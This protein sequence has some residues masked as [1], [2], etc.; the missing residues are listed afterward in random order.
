MPTGSSIN[1]KYGDLCLDPQYGIGQYI[2]QI[3]TR[4]KLKMHFR[5]RN[6]IVQVIRTKYDAAL[7]KGKN[8]IVGHLAKANPQITDKLGAALTKDERKEV[9]AWIDGHATIGTL[10]RELA[11][12]TLQEQLT[13]AE[14]WFADQKG[15]GARLLAASLVPAWARLRAVLKKNELVE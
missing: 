6:Q 11:V 12:R 5:E 4:R 13:L 15:D 8:E 7:K 1:N 9:A 14:E 10:K 3:V 2:A